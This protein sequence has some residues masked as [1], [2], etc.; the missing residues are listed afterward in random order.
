[1]IK[2]AMIDIHDRLTREKLRA[3]MLLQ[4]HDELL[5][6]VHEDEIDRVRPLVKEEMEGVRRL[7]VPLKVEVKT[8]RNWDEAH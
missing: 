8:G 6:E 2:K 4:V 5:F 3:K 7:D 1:L